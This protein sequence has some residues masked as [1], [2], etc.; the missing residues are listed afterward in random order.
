MCP[1]R[2]SQAWLRD[3]DTDWRHLR[4]YWTV[5]VIVSLADDMPSSPDLKRDQVDSIERITVPNGQGPIFSTSLESLS[6]LVTLILSKLRYEKRRVV[7]H[8]SGGKKE[9][10]VMAGLVLIGMGFT[11]ETAVNLIQTATKKSSYLSNPIQMVTLQ[12]FKY[13]WQKL[14][15]RRFEQLTYQFQ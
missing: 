15:S 13:H 10:A 11:V 3:H 6:N 9:G 1:G 7:I 8:G 12:I 2:K 4:L 5:N 14:C